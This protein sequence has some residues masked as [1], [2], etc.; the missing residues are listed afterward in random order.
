MKTRDENGTGIDRFFCDFRNLVS[1]KM[2]FLKKL[3]VR[4]HYVPCSRIRVGE[5]SAKEK[6]IKKGEKSENE[7]LRTS[8]KKVSKNGRKIQKTT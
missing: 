6:E 3:L 4:K 5:G 2:S 1:Q 8:S 7:T